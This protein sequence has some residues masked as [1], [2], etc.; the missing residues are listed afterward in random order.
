MHVYILF[1]YTRTDVYVCMYVCM[2]VRR[3]VGI[4]VHVYM[5]KQQM[6]MYTSRHMYTYG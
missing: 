1:I 3:W 6:Y 2:H 4:R 5:Y